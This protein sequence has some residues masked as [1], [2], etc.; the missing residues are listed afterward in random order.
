MAKISARKLILCE[1]LPLHFKRKNNNIEEKRF[2]FGKFLSKDTRK[3][4]SM[5]WLRN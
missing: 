5:F 2:W 1:L 3:E 4:S